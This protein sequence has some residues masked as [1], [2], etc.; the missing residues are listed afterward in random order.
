M[1]YSD[2]QFNL[3]S[4]TNDP[5]Y[6]ILVIAAVQYL[7]IDTIHKELDRQYHL[8]HFY[9]NYTSY[10]VMMIHHILSLVMTIGSYLMDINHSSIIALYMFEITN[11]PLLLYTL[12]LPY[13]QFYILRI[14]WLS[15]FLVRV[16]YGNFMI[17]YIFSDILVTQIPR[18]QLYCAIIMYM[19][20]LTANNYW[21]YKLNGIYRIK[22]NKYYNI[23]NDN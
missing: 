11:I 14:F 10:I 5:L 6:N 9:S 2:I 3:T 7:V 19:F 22:Y 18:L 13:C 21:F 16:L 4:K 20:L 1:F 15:F 23:K 8:N 12:K 17:I